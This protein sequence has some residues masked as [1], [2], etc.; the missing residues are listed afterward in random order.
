MKSLSQDELMKILR[1]ASNDIRNHAIILLA[2]RHGMRASEVCNLELKDVD[3]QN[4]QITIRRLKNSLTT[5]QPLADVQGSPLLS[6]RRVLRAWLKERGNHPSKYVFVSQKS[7]RI[8]RS[9]VHR[10]FSAL[11]EES[12]LPEGRRHFHQLKHSLAVTLVEANVNLAV[13][14]QALGHRSIASTAVYATPSDQSAGKAVV[15]A[16]AAW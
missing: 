12:G 3:L 11:A 4:G 13:I 1:L 15:S 2:F 14:K 8:S 7:G 9:Q 10:M 16:L 6:E 5:T